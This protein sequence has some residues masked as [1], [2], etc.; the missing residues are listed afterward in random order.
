M[1]VSSS[2]S[3]SSFLSMIRYELYKRGLTV[4]MMADQFNLSEDEMEDILS[5]KDRG[6]GSR[7]TLME[8][9]K[10]Y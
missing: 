3:L 4:T 10:Y 9:I 2:T 1:K 5:G 8:I 6:P 7:K